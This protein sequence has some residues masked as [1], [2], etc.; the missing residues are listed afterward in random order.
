MNQKNVDAL[1]RVFQDFATPERVWDTPLSLA[2]SVA[3]YFASRGCLGPASE[4]LEPDDAHDIRPG[5]YWG[6]LAG[7]YAERYPD[8]DFYDA[9]ALETCKLLERLAK[10][11][12]V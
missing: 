8:M 5:V 11:E 7:I 2:Q 9:H 10:G 1:A 4:V 3:Q 12:N 6:H